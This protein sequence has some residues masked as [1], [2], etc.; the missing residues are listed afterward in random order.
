[1]DVSLTYN[2]MINL[3][4]ARIYLS[5]NLNIDNF[6]NVLFM[7]L[8]RVGREGVL[9]SREA[10]SEFTEQEQQYIE[11]LNFCLEEGPEI[12]RSARR[13][14]DRVVESLGLSEERARE[15]EEI[16]QDKLCDS[17]ND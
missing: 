10:S 7:I 16:V 12:S 2:D 13:L 3:D 5:F 4:V 11:E 1:M 15:I 8:I 14:L 17:E 9:M 6:S